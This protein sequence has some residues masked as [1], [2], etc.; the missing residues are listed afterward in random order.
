MNNG[1]LKDSQMQR[2]T[3]GFSLTPQFF[4]GLLKINANV[5]GYYIRNKFSNEGAVGA[6]VAFNPTVP[7][8]SN[9][10]S[11]TSDFPGPSFMEHQR[12]RQPRGRDQGPQRRVA[13]VPQQR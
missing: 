5:K 2:V 12:N 10:A 9:I 13:G 3:A 1:I 6:A 11:G 8:Y 7:V 4:G